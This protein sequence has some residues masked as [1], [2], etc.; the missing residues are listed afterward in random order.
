MSIEERRAKIMVNKAGGTASADAKNYRVALP[1][2]WIYGLGIDEH[3]REV[4]LQFDGETIFI[5]PA[6]P[7]QYDTFLS[8][9]REKDHALLILYFYENETLC[10]K[11]CADLTTYQLSVQNQVA[12][13]LSTAFGV[14]QNP[15]WKDLQAFLE[16]RC[17]PRQRDGLR[18]YLRHLGLDQYEPLEIIRRTQGR[19]AEDQHWIEILEG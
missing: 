9:A 15:T 18:Y 1:S 12:D 4:T 6:V 14:N 11:I 2:E 16:S 8:A 17:V 5:R 3:N 13:P 7:A 19:M 10:T